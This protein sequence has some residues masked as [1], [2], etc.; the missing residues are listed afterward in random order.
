VGSCG[1]SNEPSG[2]VNDGEF[3]DYLNVLSSH[4]SEFEDDC[5]LRCCA[6][7]SGRNWPVFQRCLLPPSSG[8]PYDGGSKQSLSASQGLCCLELDS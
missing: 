6:M 2:S 1:H 7:F 4:G 3:L 8:C 5:L